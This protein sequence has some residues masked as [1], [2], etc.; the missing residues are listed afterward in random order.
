MGNAQRTNQR[1]AFVSAVI[2]A[3]S[4]AALRAQST[5]PAI[6]EVRNAEQ[7]QT[8]ANTYH[9]DSC[10]LVK[11]FV[12]AK[13]E[14]ADARARNMTACQTCKPR[15]NSELAK[16]LKPVGPAT[17]ITKEKA[18]P[19]SVGVEAYAVAM[20]TAP[21]AGFEKVSFV[22]D[23]RVTIRTAD[24]D[25][26]AI[27]RALQPLEL[28]AILEIKPGWA[29]I[30]G[31]FENGDPIRA[32]TKFNGWIKGGSETTAFLIP[33][34]MF[35]A[36]ELISTLDEKKAWT[37]ADKHLILRGVPR[38]GFSIEQLDMAMGP[39]TSTLTEE[40]ATGVVEIRSYPGKTVTIAR[41]KVT[42]I[43]TTK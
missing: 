22:A 12:L 35:D 5:V 15:N 23:R 33:K 17:S 39:P 31:G 25:S 30:A 9:L 26:A 10:P 32:N 8:Q 41:G 4:A 18:G 1:I 34:S 42:R 20:T 28:A 24:N 43:L 21:G 2:V 6:Y 37:V 27:V 13:V 3:L 14:I 40:T 36:A 38:V 19:V 16:L 29:R 7:Y 11:S